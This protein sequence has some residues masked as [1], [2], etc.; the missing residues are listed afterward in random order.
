MVL[1]G[2]GRGVRVGGEHWGGRD[3]IRG[4]RTPSEQSCLVSRAERGFEVMPPGINMP[5]EVLRLEL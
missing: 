3:H 2:L 4:H 5:S 1:E